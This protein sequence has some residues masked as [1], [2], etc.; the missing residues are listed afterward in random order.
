VLND[1]IEGLAQRMQSS[2]LTVRLRRPPGH[3]ALAVLPGVKTVESAEDGSL[4]LY[5]DP[6]SDPTEALLK[7]AVERD[8]GLT[9]LLPQRA[10]LEDIFVEITTEDTAH[11][12]ATL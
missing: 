5:H 12:E 7:L 1:S 4:R 11:A 3:D 8:W 10:T 6:A 2:I 9:T